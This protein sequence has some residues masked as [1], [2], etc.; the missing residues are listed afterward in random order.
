MERQ[1]RTSQE[2]IL[3]PW[4]RI[5]VPSQGIHII[6]QASYTPKRKVIFLM[7]LSEM[8]TLKFNSL[9]SFLVFP[10]LNCTLNTITDKL[11]LRHPEDNCLWVKDY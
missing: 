6:I 10:R 3:Q 1:E 4:G 8:N 11:K 5:L 9:E 2:T 7:L